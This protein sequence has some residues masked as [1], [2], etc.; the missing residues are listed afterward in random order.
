MTPAVPRQRVIPFGGWITAGIVFL[1]GF[2]FC[3]VIFIREN[4]A[5]VPVR[6]ILP[7]PVAR[8]SWPATPC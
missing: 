6:I 7:D 8:C 2:L 4:H 3:N 5:P 1:L